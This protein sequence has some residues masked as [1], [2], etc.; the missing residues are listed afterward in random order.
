MNQSDNGQNMQKNSDNQHRIWNVSY[1]AIAIWCW[2]ITAVI[3]RLWVYDHVPDAYKAQVF[4]E[5]ILTLAIVDVVVVHAV[6][7]YKQAK[8]ANRQAEIALKQI[9]ITD[10]PWIK[11]KCFFNSGISFLE[12]GQLST[13]FRFIVRNVGKSVAVN[14]RIR[15][16]LVVPDFGGFSHE[17]VL[18][19]QLEVCAGMDEPQ[20]PHEWRERLELSS[21]VFPNEDYIINHGF[22]ASAEEVKRG[23]S[24]DLGVYELYL[25]GCVNYQIA[26]YAAHHHTHFAYMV[27]PHGRE[28]KGGPLEIGENVPSENL[29]LHELMRGG[30]YAD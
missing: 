3:V 21:V 5:S 10:R 16:R 27:F 2:L 25:V 9:E 15:A 28:R 11:F 29:T 24:G 13:W 6:M 30:D 1:T 17:H 20:V 19:R 23:D 18:K 14:T 4:V 12:N 22:S 7:Y 26:G 8:E